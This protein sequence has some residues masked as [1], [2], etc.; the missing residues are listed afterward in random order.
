[1]ITVQIFGGLG[2]QLFQYAFGRHISLMKYD[3][4]TLDY[5]HQMIRTDFDGEALTKITDI[6]DLPVELYIGK[7]RKDLVNR[8]NLKIA[9]RLASK[10]YRLTRCT[11][12]ERN[13]KRD[14]DK[15]AKC[16]DI[17]IVGYWQSEEYFS[18]IKEIIKK[19]FKFKCEEQIKNLE[20]YKEILGS[21]SVSLHIRGKDYLVKDQFI[22][23]GEK[24]YMDAIDLI[25]KTNSDLKCF[26]FTDDIDNVSKNYKKLS[27][28]SRIV[29][30]KTSFSS[31][32]VDLLLMSKC[33]HNVICNSSFSWWAA[34]LN[35]NPAKIIAAPRQW[36]A[37]P[38]YDGSRIIPANWY[39]I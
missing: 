26:I 15:I 28:L 20:I 13:Y 17:Y 38:K 9:D 23:H 10:I 35:N 5:Y 34:W 16:G 7:S 25:S 27:K 36:F 14:K 32:A 19:D 29:D 4:L 18:D 1:M 8:Y 24:Y 30:I 33:K 12:E 2:N 3:D 39:K 31:D 21:N 6:F 37:D 11:I 22:I